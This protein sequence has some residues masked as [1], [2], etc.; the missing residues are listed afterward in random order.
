MG[1]F[2]VLSYFA[3]IIDGEGCICI[4]K[5]QQPKRK[6]PSYRLSIRIGNTDLRMLNFLYTEFGGSIKDKQTK[7]KGMATCYEWV[8]SDTKAEFLLRLVKDYVVCKKDE[9][10]LALR[11]RELSKIHPGK[12]VPE[13]LEVKNGIFEKLKEMHQNRGVRSWKQIIEK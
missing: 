4:S 12:N 2:S 6:N 10:L 9:V 3:G 1:E 8:V 11:F 13:L 7:V 5:Y